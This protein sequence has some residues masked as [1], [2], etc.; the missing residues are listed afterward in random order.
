MQLAENQDSYATN[1]PCYR[2]PES[3]IVEQAEREVTGDVLA[4]PVLRSLDDFSLLEF[5][6]DDGDQYQ[7]RPNECNV[8]I[9]QTAQ[10]IL[11]V[12][13][14]DMVEKIRV[15][16]G[17][18]NS[19]VASLVNVSRPSLYNHINN[20]ESPVSIKNYQAVYD[21]A[22]S[23]E[24]ATSGCALKQGLKSILVDGKTLLAYLKESPLDA[25]KILAVSG[26]VADK[27]QQFDSTNR[28]PSIEQE[29]K[30]SKAYTKAG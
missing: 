7:L 24:S 22:I 5:Y 20:K 25:E 10:R 17:L 3:Y 14:K 1:A 13:V 4:V 21:L 30:A 27:L 2:E 28:S 19:Q 11:S 18:N 15:V 23:V 26:V 9:F 6:L 16:F 8:E 29:R 12:S